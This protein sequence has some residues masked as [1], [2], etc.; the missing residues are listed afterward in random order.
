MHA[1]SDYNVIGRTYDATRRADP[2]ITERL[3]ALL[4]ATPGSR[5]VDIACGTGNYTCALAQ[6]GLTLTG[7]DCSEVMLSAAREKSTEIAWHVGAV[8]QLPFADA[9]FDCATCTLA[10]HHFTDRPAAFREVRRVLRDGRLVIFTSSPQQMRRYWLNHYFPIALQ[11]SIEKMPDLADVRRALLAAGFAIV[12]TEPFA[13]TPE[14]CD[15][16][17][18]SAKHDP[19]RYLDPDF[20]RG[21]STFQSLIDAEE[22]DQGCA[23]L[24]EDLRC[25]RF[26]AIAQRYAHDRGDYTFVAAAT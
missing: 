19:Q 21:I 3:A 17:L 20:R 1:T 13:V 5:I 15:H 24:A 23:A 26:D 11:R 9:T 12:T 4:E 10:I 14:L 6:R 16:F 2:G 25:G 8:E 7:I 22:L 18:Y